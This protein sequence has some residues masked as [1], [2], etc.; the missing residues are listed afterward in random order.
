[1]KAT[2]L[3]WDQMMGMYYKLLIWHKTLLI[4]EY[5]TNILINKLIICSVD[6]FFKLIC[7]K[8]TNLRV[9]YKDIIKMIKVIKL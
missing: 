6:T 3:R 1:M 9:S 7:I 2:S 5:Y 8:K 4:L